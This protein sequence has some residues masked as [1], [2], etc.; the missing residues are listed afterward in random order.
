M[1]VIKVGKYMLMKSAG[2]KYLGHHQYME[3]PG[4]LTK[5]KGGGRTSAIQ[6]ASTLNGVCRKG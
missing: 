2:D 4:Y 6:N 3:G 5:K 1:T